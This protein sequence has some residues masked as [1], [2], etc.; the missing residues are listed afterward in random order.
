MWLAINVKLAARRRRYQMAF[1]EI[2]VANANDRGARRPI[3]FARG[4]IEKS[5][6]ERG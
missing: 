1:R 4:I 2:I 5:A 6:D 3:Q